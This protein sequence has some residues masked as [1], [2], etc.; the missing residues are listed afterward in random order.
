MARVMS[1]GKKNDRIPGLRRTEL[2]QHSLAFGLLVINLTTNTTRGPHG[3]HWGLRYLGWPG[4]L[5][6]SFYKNNACALSHARTRQFG[7]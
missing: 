7:M 2:P 6:V 1:G 4:K 5:W 3:E